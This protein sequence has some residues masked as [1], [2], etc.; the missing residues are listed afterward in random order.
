MFRTFV[1]GVLAMLVL[2]AIVAGLI[3][4]N[5]PP[6]SAGTKGTKGIDCVK[7][8]SECGGVPLRAIF[9]CCWCRR[10]DCNPRIPICN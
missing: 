3:Q 7:I 9:D 4:L 6:A 5:A 8:C 10:G 2:V 1:G